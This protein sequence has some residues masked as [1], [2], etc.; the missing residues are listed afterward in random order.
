MSEFYGELRRVIRQ[1][2]MLSQAAAMM[3]HALKQ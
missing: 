2:N 1:Q 3:R